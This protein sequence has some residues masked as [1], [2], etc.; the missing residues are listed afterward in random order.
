MTP[1]RLL[2]ISLVLG[3]A[4]PGLTGAAAQ[5]VTLTASHPNVV[6]FW[7]EVANRTILAQS[8]TATTPE[9]QRASFAHDPATVHLAIYDAV[10]AIEGRYRPFAVRPAA[11]AAGAST[12]AA[13][14]AAAHGVLLALFPN[15]GAVYQPAYD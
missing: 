11:P 15:R 3:L 12:E 1:R 13:V 6:S 7:N 5:P 2:A 4:A 9:E 8:P 10:V 14:S